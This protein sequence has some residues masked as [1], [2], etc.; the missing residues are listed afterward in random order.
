MTWFYLLF[1]E[2]M[3]GKATRKNRDKVDLNGHTNYPE[4]LG[5]PQLFGDK[6]KSIKDFN[7][8]NIR[9]FTE[10][11]RSSLA[12][13]MEGVKIRFRD[14]LYNTLQRMDSTDGEIFPYRSMGHYWFVI[15][16][17]YMGKKLNQKTAAEYDYVKS[18]SNWSFLVRVWK[19]YRLVNNK[20]EKIPGSEYDNVVV[21]KVNSENRDLLV[22]TKKD[23]KWDKKWV[24]NDK[25]ETVIP[26]EYEYKDVE[27]VECEKKIFFV[28]TVWDKKW[29]MDKSWNW[30]IKPEYNDIKAVTRYNYEKNCEEMSFIVTTWGKEWKKWVINDRWDIM[31]PVQCDE[32]FVPFRGIIWNMVFVVKELGRYRLSSFDGTSIG[33]TR[34]YEKYQV[35]DYGL[36]HQ[37]NNV[38]LISNDGQTFTYFQFWDNWIWDNWK[39]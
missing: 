30:V 1:Y 4:L 18:L 9:K 16:K 33:D 36:H 14:F 31:I 8:K 26:L 34:K 10:N 29:I 28:V 7:I 25:W 12:G 35:N 2:V 39:K 32:I 6:K 15:P 37:D 20:W 17:E 38:T 22:V 5:D 3:T 27:V 24:I 11:V 13:T 19:K 21:E 23:E